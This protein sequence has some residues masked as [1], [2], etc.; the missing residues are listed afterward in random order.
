MSDTPF[1][2]PGSSDPQQEPTRPVSPYVW[3]CL[4]VGIASVL[5]RVLV[6]GQKEQ[7]A[8]MFIGLPTAMAMLIA[9]LPRA[10]SATGMI[11]KG[12]TLFLLLLGILLIEGF[13]CIL[14]AAPL[15]YGIGFI[16]GILV[17]GA[18]KRKELD[19][20]LRVVVLPV[21]AIMSLEGVTGLLSFPRDEAITVSHEVALSPAEARAVLAKGPQFDLTELP[22]FLKLGFPAPHRIEGTGLEMG[23][24]WLI[25]FAGGEGKPGDLKAQVVESSETK[26]R[27]ACVADTSHISHWLDW[28][29]AEWTIEPSSSGSRVTL[30]MR[31]SRLLD[32]AW[33]FKPIERY[34]VRKAGGYFLEQTFKSE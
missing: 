33:Y 2:S 32:P 1:A 25:H 18:R 7:T 30:T 4:A 17:D 28:K 12:I 22:P 9:F 16:V 19:K 3:L 15:F 20:R 14:M 10:S 29:D 34:G 24:T 8:L 5:F 11:T 6:L 23:D 27:V 31:Y 26:I 21:L 13:I